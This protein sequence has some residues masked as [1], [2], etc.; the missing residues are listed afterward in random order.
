MIL[1][2]KKLSTG[3]SIISLVKPFL[4]GLDFFPIIV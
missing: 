2:G 1:Y 3:K 4:E